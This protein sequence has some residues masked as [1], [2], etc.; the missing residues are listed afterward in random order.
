MA[1]ISCG[2]F[3][4][5]YIQFFLLYAIIMILLSMTL[6]F[7]YGNIT[8]IE[9]YSNILLTLFISN[10][11]L[12]FCY[13]PE[14]ITK[15]LVSDK[16][17]EK[18]NNKKQCLFQQNKND[19]KKLAIEYIFN[20][21]S[22]RI[23]VKDIILIFM[24]S[25]M[26]LVIDYIKI[27]IQIKNVEKGDQLIL[28]EYYNFAILLFIVIFAYFLY[29]MKIYKHQIYSLLIII[30]L[31]L[32][33]YFLKIFHYYGLERL[34]NL[35][36]DIFLQ[37]IAAI[38]ESL[39]IIFSKALME[40]KYFSPYKVCYIFGFINTTIIIIL[41][42]IFSFIKS[43]TKSWFFSLNYKGYYYLDNINSIINIYGYK[44]IGLFFCS[45]FYSLL[46][47]FFNFTISRFTVY[48]VFLLLQNKEVTSNLCKELT[49]KKGYIF[50][51][52]LL[53][54]HLI[55]F[56]VILVFLEIIELKFCNLDQNLKKYIKNRADLETRESLEY[57]ENDNDNSME[58]ND[59]AETLSEDEEN[60]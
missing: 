31:G 4:R 44:L 33:R 56:F 11:G 49:T 36:F 41:L 9:N 57:I 39:I 22:D 53:I 30:I 17:E 47:L 23:T 37:F 8:N 6:Y 26:L 14:V 5:K 54:S 40:I 27:S 10:F 25:I 2:T 20:D 43:N 13:I 38:F 16:K 21:F 24:S 59:S 35:I 46:K 34:G 50:V 51:S 60:K 12:I 42:I 48:H 52:M 58:R 55:E 28:N 19:N 7:I 15:K 29:K 32:F 45:V 1:I 18:N 3:E